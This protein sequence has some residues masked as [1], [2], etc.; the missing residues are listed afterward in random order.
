M[1]LTQG[2][3]LFA[4]LHEDAIRKVIRAFRIARPKYFFYACPPLGLGI[5]SIDFWI[6]P[7][8]PVPGTNSGMPISIQIGKVQLDFTPANPGLNLPAPLSLGPN[9]FAL[10]LTV[11]VCFLC[12]VLIKMPVPR[13]IEREREQEREDPHQKDRIHKECAQ[14]SIWATG[15]PIATP[16]SKGG[17]DIGLHIDHLVIKE[18]GALETLLE[19]YS[20]TM[21]NS[22]LNAMRFPVEQFA[23]GAFGKLSLVDGP[24]IADNQL[25]VWGDI[26]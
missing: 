12:G 20:E 6:I 11:E 10:S 24:T 14:L 5:P 17:R 19:C 23:L 21:L 26:S 1:A 13:E 7:P 16:N 8:L 22:L 15:H 18:V 9:Q 25:K 2:H 4:G 3:H